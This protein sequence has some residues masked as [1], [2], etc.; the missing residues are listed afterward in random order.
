MGNRI[1]K[2]I[3]CQIRNLL[4]QIDL[5]ISNFSK[6]FLLEVVIMK[7]RLHLP[8]YSVAPLK[9]ARLL[10]FKQG[11]HKTNYKHYGLY[12]SEIPN[13]KSHFNTL[14]FIIYISEQPLIYGC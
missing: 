13:Q 5:D 12:K 4:P 6:H 14:P 9:R 8:L 3:L 2:L 11:H 7:S 1:L 10:E